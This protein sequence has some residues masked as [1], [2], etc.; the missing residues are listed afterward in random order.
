MS[1]AKYIFICYV[2]KNPELRK[3]LP[4]FEL[5][6]IT[7]LPLDFCIVNKRVLCLLTT[8]NKFLLFSILHVTYM[9]PNEKGLGIENCQDDFLRIF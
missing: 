1:K 2:V 5:A 6:G 4:I 3:I 9:A 7:I 8:F